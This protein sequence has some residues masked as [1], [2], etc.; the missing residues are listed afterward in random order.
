M[1]KITILLS[2][3]ALL[4]G[5]YAVGNACGNKS[6]ASQT[7]E[8]G[9]TCGATCN[10][11]KAQKTG[12]DIN[13]PNAKAE[14]AQVKVVS[15]K[16]VSQSTSCPHMGSTADNNKHSCCSGMKANVSGKAGIQK[17]QESATTKIDKNKIAK[18]DNQP[19]DLSFNG[20]EAAR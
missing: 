16:T 1:K 2:L 3:L 8:N 18:N 9:T 10:S 20:Q 7:S 15:E 4:I 11:I 17:Q 5:S 14:T 12:A 19:K 13:I 6:K